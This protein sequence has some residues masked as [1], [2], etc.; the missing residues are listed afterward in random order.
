MILIKFQ[1]IKKIYRLS[2]PEINFL[3]LIPSNYKKSWDGKLEDLISSGVLLSDA[4][5]TRNNIKYRIKTKLLSIQGKY[6]I[7][8]GMHFEMVGTSQ[9]EHIADKGRYPQFTFTNKNIALACAYCNGFEKKSSQNVVKKIN[10]EYQKCEFSIVHPYFDSFEN[11][12][13]LSFDGADISLS[14]KNNSVKGENT[15]KI[16]KLMETAQAAMRG[17]AYLRQESNKKL[18]SSSVKKRNTII[19]NKYTF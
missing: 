7:Y 5:K 3:S 1:Q 18:N 4:A 15:I 11:H 10:K 13:E 19:L 8:C 17:A 16:F 12:I 14:K 6:C 9:R 2:K